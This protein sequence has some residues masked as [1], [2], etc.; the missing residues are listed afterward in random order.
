MI[1]NQELTAEAWMTKS[2]A[3][4][5]LQKS[6]RSL[7][8]LVT[9]GKVERRTRPREG[10]PPRPPEPVFNRADID[11]LTAIEPFPM[12]P[13]DDRQLAPRERTD[14]ALK[15]IAQLLAAVVAQSRTPAAQLPPPTQWLTLQAASQV[16]GLSTRLLRKLIHEGRL[17][18]LADGRRTFKVRRDELEAFRADKIESTGETPRA[19]RA[20]RASLAPTAINGVAQ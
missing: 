7:D 19:I 1:K 2:E 4:A 16:S 9:A 15:V 18:A 20:T 3:M 8:R 11:R 10:N 5:A 13:A 17:P 14:P 6:E 12:E